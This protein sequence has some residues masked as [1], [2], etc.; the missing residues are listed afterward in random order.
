MI[1]RLVKGIFILFNYFKRFYHTFINK[2]RL[3]GYGN[4]TRVN[5]KSN[6]GTNT[7]LGNNCNFNGINILGKGKVVI[8][9][10]F[11]SGEECVF[12]TSYH[13]Y[14]YGS[15]IPYD[16]TNVNKEIKINDNVWLGTRVIILGGVELGEGCII[17]AGSVVV[18]NIPKYGIAG[19]NPAKVFKYRDIEHYES[20]KEQGKFY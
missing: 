10:N 12:I 4:R 11:H 14:D 16:E 6:L 7:Y 1:K 2:L 13:N 3:K 5:N 19:G 9:D 20:L 17:Q 15:K 18:S 8:G